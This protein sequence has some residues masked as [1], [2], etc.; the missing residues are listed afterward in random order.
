M[1]ALLVLLVITTRQIRDEAIRQAAADT[2]VTTEP[3][4]DEV[5][6]EPAYQWPEWEVAL[7]VQQNQPPLP[8]TRTDHEHRV[9]KGSMI[10]DL[11]RFH[12]ERRWS[13]LL[14]G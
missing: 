13:R 7:V 12:V 5:D 10:G 4:P 1:G 2:L 8:Q 3:P 14:V 6:E 11:V 9:R